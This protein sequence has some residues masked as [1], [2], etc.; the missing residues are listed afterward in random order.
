MIKA[1]KNFFNWRSE[2]QANVNGSYYS[3]LIQRDKDH[4]EM[5]Q[6]FEDDKVVR[7]VKYEAM[8][9]WNEWQNAPMI[10]FGEHEFK[11]CILLIRP[12]MSCY[13]VYDT[14]LAKFMNVDISKMVWEE[15]EKLKNNNCP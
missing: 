1:I 11:N 5:M 14:D 6:K 4:N 10:K 15:Y 9:L 2:R 13:N 7:E 12:F 3:F 8:R